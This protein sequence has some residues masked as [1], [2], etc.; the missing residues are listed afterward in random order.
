MVVRLGPFEKIATIQTVK[1]NIA[2]VLNML[3]HTD[4]TYTI[5]RPEKQ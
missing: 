4:P 2:H 1:W 5:C 3:W